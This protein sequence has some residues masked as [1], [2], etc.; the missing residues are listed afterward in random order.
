SSVPH[1]SYATAML[2]SAPPPSSTKGRSVAM[3]TNPRW[4][5]W[6]PGRHAPDAGSI[7]GCTRRSMHPLWPRPLPGPP[8]IGPPP[9]HF[10]VAAV[11][12]GHVSGRAQQVARSH[13]IGA[14]GPR[15][16]VRRERDVEDL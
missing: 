9:D 10:V 15:P 7:D 2:R 11:G 12:L 16:L 1:V 4:P 14:A 5:G 13:G 8:P 6:S 3:S